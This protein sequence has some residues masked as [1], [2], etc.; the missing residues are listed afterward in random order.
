MTSYRDSLLHGA[1]FPIPPL[2]IQD[3]L[4]IILVG[5]VSFLSII[6]MRYTLILCSPKLGFH[7]FNL[8]ELSCSVFM[9]GSRS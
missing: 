5:N 4:L 3:S 8:E 7:G 1:T 6:F 9:K 2:L